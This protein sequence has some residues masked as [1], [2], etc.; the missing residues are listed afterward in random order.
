[1]TSIE[2]TIWVSPEGLP[3]KVTTKT[4]GGTSPTTSTITYKDWGSNVKVEVP[5]ADKVA[6]FSSI[7][8]G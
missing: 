5:A 6:D 1:V 8:G 4:V 3:L 2:T 7:M